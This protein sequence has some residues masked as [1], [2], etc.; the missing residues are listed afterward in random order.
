MIDDQSHGKT[1]AETTLNYTF[2]STYII[3]EG[4]RTN[5]S[6]WEAITG[7]ASHVMDGACL[8]KQIRLDMLINH[9]LQWLTSV[10]PIAAC[11][12]PN[13]VEFNVI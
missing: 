13:D 11:N 8:K 12:K 2:F 9:F 1:E 6:E 4:Y 7:R 3:Y 5:Y 10:L